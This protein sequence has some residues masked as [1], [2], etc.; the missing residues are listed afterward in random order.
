M[1]PRKV[2]GGSTSPEG[3]AI[4]QQAV[5]KR[6]ICGQELRHPKEGLCT[7][8]DAQ[9]V[10]GLEASL[11]MWGGQIT[12]RAR[13]WGWGAEAGEETVHNRNTTD[14]LAVRE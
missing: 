6:F 1:K 3:R 11:E 8:E 13:G 9:S 4:L 7:M 5:D 10:T 2:R 14:L 12:D